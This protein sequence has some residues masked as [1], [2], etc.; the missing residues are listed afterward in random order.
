MAE[1]ESDSDIAIALGE[2]IRRG[3]AFFQSQRPIAAWANWQSV[4]RQSP[5]NMPAQQALDHLASAF[6]LPDVARKPL[7]FLPPEGEQ[8]RERWNTVFQKSAMA[9]GPEFQADPTA[10]ALMFRSILDDDKTDASA[11]W[12]LAVCLAWAGSNR[13][14]IDALDTFVHLA[15]DSQPDQAADAWTLAELLRHGAGAEELADC[16]SLSITLDDQ[17]FG[18]D[19]HD[20]LKT[21]GPI[22]EYRNLTAPAG[23]M[24]YAADLLEKPLQ[25]GPTAVP[26][27]ASVIAAGGKLKIS[28]PASAESGLFFRDLTQLLQWLTGDKIAVD[29]GILNLSML[30]ASVARFKLPAD[31]SP[32]RRDQLSKQ[33]VADYFENLWIHQPRHGLNGMTPLAV[34]TEAKSGWKQRLEGLIG[35]Q[36]QMARRPAS[37]PIYQEYEFDRLR[38]RLGLIQKP[39]KD[40]TKGE[41]LHQ[42]LL[43][44]NLGYV[45]TV[46]P[47]KMSE[48]NLITAW[49]TATA[50]TDDELSIQLGDEIRNR[51]VL[52]FSEIPVSRWAAPYLRHFVKDGDLAGALD[53]L[54][55]ALMLDKKYREGW[56]QAKLLMWRAQAVSR[57]GTPADAEKAWI[58]ACEHPDTPQ[59]RR[60]DSITDLIE[61]EEA[62][63]ELLSLCARWLADSPSE[64][65]GGL[66]ELTLEELES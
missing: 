50:C 27:A 19:Y 14:S 21:L 66:I 33:S 30:D 60:F 13:A 34:S 31:L 8:R 49:E 12:N 26:I 11:A 7:R 38:Y 9:F 5:E 18:S 43:W 1:T 54:D 52:I 56:D 6:D 46:A 58:V 47:S 61:V 15:A 28:A 59:I 39:G 55:H 3:W 25:E 24:P 62:G 63:T 20:F 35:F 2:Q 22:S 32:L 48:L 41:A 64:F 37:R 23:D 4:I 36:E 44:Y 51:P 40:D 42:S 45:R 10:A 57:L 29:H 53:L 65:L 16:V 17:Q